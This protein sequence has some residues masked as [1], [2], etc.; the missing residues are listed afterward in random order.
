MIIIAVG[1]TF[2][3]IT[4][5]V[6]IYYWNNTRTNDV[7]IGHINVIV[8]LT[9]CDYDMSNV[10]SINNTMICFVGVIIDSSDIFVAM[11]ING[12][13]I[14]V[15]KIMKSS[16]IFVA[17][18]I[19]SGGIFVTEIMDKSDLFLAEIYPK[20]FY[21]L[22]LIICWLMVECGECCILPVQMI[23]IFLSQI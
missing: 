12:S 1:I 8:V 23:Q 4:V 20:T 22:V 2:T 11:I 17:M 14:F 15:I 13:D 5:I 21:C 18:I 10:V 7:Y 3:V 19:D 6:T 16:G 9:C